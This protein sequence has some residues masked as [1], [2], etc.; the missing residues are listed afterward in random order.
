MLLELKEKDRVMDRKF[1]EP[2]SD[3][4]SGAR[5]EALGRREADSAPAS[6]RY[7]CLAHDNEVAGGR[8]EGGG[9][10]TTCGGLPA[11]ACV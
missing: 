3:S 5:Q 1:G 8:Q 9:L 11:C 6:H 10:V 7:D 4:E 2:D